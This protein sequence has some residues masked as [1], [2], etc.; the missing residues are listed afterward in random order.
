MCPTRW[1]SL[2][3]PLLFHPM[4]SK[5]P[6][7]AI[8]ATSIEF[9]QEHA[10]NSAW[11]VATLAEI[12]DGLTD[13]AIEVLLP[14]CHHA[15]L[16]ARSP[17]VVLLGKKWNDWGDTWLGNMDRLGGGGDRFG[18]SPQKLDIIILR[19]LKQP[20]VLTYELWMPSSCMIIQRM[21]VCCAHEPNL[22]CM[23]GREAY[24][25]GGTPNK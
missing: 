21:R 9:P 1:Y 14:H 11:A 5:H 6:K 4:V 18:L 7:W 8:H 23:G 13:G 20:L 10:W 17:C 12:G 24:G 25:R 2:H 16:S 19:S 15:R 22:K 3:L